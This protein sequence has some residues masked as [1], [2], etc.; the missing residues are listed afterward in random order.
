MTAL[1]GAGELAAW[2]VADCEARGV[3]LPAVESRVRA[4]QR[5]I[6]DRYRV[7]LQE[8]LSPRRDKHLAHA[9]MVAVWLAWSI[10]A[11]ST[12]KL[13]QAFGHRDH[14]TIMHSIARIKAM[15]EDD[16]AFDAEMR[17]LQFALMQGVPT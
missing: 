7:T 12:T 3:P 17:A 14:T 4:I 13:G 5:A 2:V 9:R 8:M 11:H 16:P 10:T 1:T 15:M 6:C